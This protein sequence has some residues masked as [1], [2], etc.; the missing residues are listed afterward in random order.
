MRI[1]ERKELPEKEVRC[2]SCESLLAYN[3]NDISE[4]T[5]ELFG[6]WHNSKSIRCPVCKTHITVEIDGEKV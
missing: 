4:S 3:K 6:D 1:I 2:P 5:E